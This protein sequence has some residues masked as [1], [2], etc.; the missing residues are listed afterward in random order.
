MN[1]TPRPGPDRGRGHVIVVGRSPDKMRE[2]IDVLRTAGFTVTGT[3]DR[4]QA[5]DAIAAHD[6]LFAVVAGGSV[7]QQLEAELC[8]A[9]EPKGA[10]VVRAFIGHQDPA[11]HFEDHVLPQLEQLDARQQGQQRR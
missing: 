10:E 6:Q 7:D 1:E 5:L 4:D 11:R 9:A 8:A 3:F 2:A